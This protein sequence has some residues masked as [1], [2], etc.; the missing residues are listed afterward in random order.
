MAVMAVKKFS[1]RRLI[2][3]ALLAALFTTTLPTVEAEAA[4]VVDIR[5]G[6]QRRINNAREARGLRTLKVNVLMTTF[7][8]DH[9]LKMGRAGSIFHDGS[10]A[11][12][13]E[14]PDGAWWRAEN[15]G[16]VTDGADVA[17]RMHRAFMNS[18]GHKAN[19]LN[20]RA[21]H[22]GIGVVKVNG[23]VWVVERFADMKP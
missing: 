11:L 10:T 4:T 21:T 15:V 8:T 7:A 23:K 16:Y 18:A 9:A 20:R 5:R 22:M 2:A 13:N 19:I 1:V 3:V 6:L 12:W 17:K 14:V